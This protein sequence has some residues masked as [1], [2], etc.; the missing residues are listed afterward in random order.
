M[1]PKKIPPSTLQSLTS[2]ISHALFVLNTIFF[3]S[4][5]FSICKN[6]SVKSN[7]SGV[8]DEEHPEIH[9]GSLIGEINSGLYHIAGG[10]RG[11][12]GRGFDAGNKIDELFD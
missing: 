3:V 10:G 5:A 9:L 7:S 11:R 1:S 4:L 2:I 12:G 8:E 6:C